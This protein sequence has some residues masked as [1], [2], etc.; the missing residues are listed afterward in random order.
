VIVD[1]KSQTQGVVPYLP[2]DQVLKRALAAQPQP[3][4]NP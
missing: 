3:G 2:L 1:S 4:A